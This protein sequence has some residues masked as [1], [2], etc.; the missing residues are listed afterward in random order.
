[1]REYEIPS[2]ILDAKEK[3]LIEKIT[4]EYEKFIS[5]GVI[6]QV[7]NKVGNVIEKITP[8]KAKK[9]LNK[10][11]ELISEWDIIKKTLEHAG[12]GFLVL[13]KHA[14]LFTINKN[15]TVK[16][17]NRA[18]YELS[19][20]EHICTLRSYN[21]EKIL[22]GRN[23][24][25]RCAAVLEGAATGAPGL[26]GV[27]FNI[28]L[29]FLLYFRAVQSIA[30]YYGYDV[31]S[32]PRELEFAASVM[33]SSLSP[34]K[35]QGLD[36]L[37]G[38]IGKMMLAANFTALK[39]ALEKTYVEM[40]KKGGA[41]LLYVQIRALA[42]S[43]AEKALQ[44]A[45]KEGI[46]AGVFRKLLEQI[47]KRIPKE[48]GKKAVPLLGAFIGAWSDSY[49]MDRILKGSNLIYHKRYLFEKEHRVNLL[50]GNDIV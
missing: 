4:K 6:G 32:D 26:P 45:G 36:T 17:F 39:T 35:E 14:S 31:K 41:E 15:D 33:L 21:I 48:A 13:H 7:A 50:L 11:Q 9:L 44:N 18:N 29:S 46:E 3:E 28:A 37:T 5:S 42:N 27:P 49:Y 12:K 40:A 38:L 20:F 8:E 43:A 23:Y 30:L 25:D 24:L 22:C 34:T 1:M 10:T 2:P 19:R 47:G 16:I